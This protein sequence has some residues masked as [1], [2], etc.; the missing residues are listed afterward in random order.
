MLLVLMLFSVL[1][2][3]LERWNALDFFYTEIKKDLDGIHA[4]ILEPDRATFRRNFLDQLRQKFCHACALVSGRVAEIRVLEQS[5]ATER[6]F[7]T[8]DRNIFAENIRAQD[9]L[10]IADD[11]F[12]K[13][14]GFTRL[15]LMRQT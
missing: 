4:D 13:Q 11:G 1:Q 7:S 2:L 9:F 10:R 8:P 15:S 5:F 6:S 12:E 3:L 14:L